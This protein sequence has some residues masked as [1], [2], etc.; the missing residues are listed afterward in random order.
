MQ[1]F[2]ESRKREASTN[3][4]EKEAQPLFRF[5]QPLTRHNPAIQRH[6]NEHQPL[7]WAK[8]MRH[9]TRNEQMA[10]VWVVSGVVLCS[11]D[12]CKLVLAIASTSRTIYSG[13][14]HLCFLR[15]HYYHCQLHCGR[16]DDFNEVKP[17]SSASYS[18][19]ASASHLKRPL[20][21]LTVSRLGQ[22]L[23]PAKPVQDAAARRR[24]HQHHILLYPT[25]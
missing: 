16:H 5:L 3:G 17:R 7:S 4:R 13:R 24:R 2:T 19:R 11:D 21:Y 14:H 20:A 6:I 1:L 12:V 23:Q 25:D 18:Y 15:T 9:Q 22:V 10:G 8:S